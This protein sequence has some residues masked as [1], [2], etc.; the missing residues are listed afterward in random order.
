MS[1]VTYVFG[2]AFV[3]RLSLSA[4]FG[5]RKCRQRPAI[6]LHSMRRLV[7]SKFTDEPRLDPPH[8]LRNCLTTRGLSQDSFYVMEPGQSLTL[9]NRLNLFTP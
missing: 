5:R 9:S 7:R 4:F 1:S 8:A 3:V 6:F 2:F